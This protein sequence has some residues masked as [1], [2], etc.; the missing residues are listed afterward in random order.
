[1]DSGVLQLRRFQLGM[2]RG[3]GVNHQRFHVSHVR[4]QGEDLQR[5]DEFE[6]LGLTA[7]DIEGK[8]RRAAVGEIF[9][10]PRVV[11][12]IGQGRMI[13]FFHL[14]VVHQVLHDLFCVLRV[15]FQTE[16]KRFRSLQ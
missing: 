8:D 16:R 14:R 12:M 5:V 1:M 7:F 2:G 3:S 9:L 4:E 11:G 6:R 15:T 10:I 13:D